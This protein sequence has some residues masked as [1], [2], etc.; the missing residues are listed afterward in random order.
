MLMADHDNV[1]FRVVGDDLNDAAL[2]TTHT[3]HFRARYAQA[4]WLD[5]VE[6]VYRLGFA[7]RS[8]SAFILERDKPGIG[9][10][11]IKSDNSGYSTHGSSQSLS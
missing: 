2:G 5:R 8:A 7:D 6:S 11:S 10:L 4:P 1:S 9:S 3:S